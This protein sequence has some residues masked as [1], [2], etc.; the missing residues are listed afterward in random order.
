[1]ADRDVPPTPG[2]DRAAPRL[3]ELPGLTRLICACGHGSTEHNLST[4]NLHRTR[5]D[6]GSPGGLCGCAR[7]VHTHTERT[8]RI[9]TLEAVEPSTLNP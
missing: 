4:N 5:C 3:I 9:I 6:T 8:A 2:D 1:M 7:F